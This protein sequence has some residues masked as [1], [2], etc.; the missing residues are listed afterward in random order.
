VTTGIFPCQSKLKKPSLLIKVIKEW[1]ARFEKKKK[2]VNIKYYIISELKFTLLYSCN[3]SWAYFYCFFGSK[4]IL[5]FLSVR[6]VT[7]QIHHHMFVFVNYDF[8]FRGSSVFDQ[9]RSVSPYYLS[10]PASQRYC[11]TVRKHN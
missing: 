1:W 6:L 10:E 7:P 8:I 2:K 11:T 3:D 5:Q 9:F 4:N